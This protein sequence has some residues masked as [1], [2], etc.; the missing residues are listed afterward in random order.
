MNPI[1]Y[2]DF[3]PQETA[4]GGLF[5][6][7]DYSNFEDCVAAMNH[8][9]ERNPVH[10]IQCET[11]TLPNMHNISEDGSHDTELH[12]AGHTIWYQFLRLWY[13]ES[14]SPEA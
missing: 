4:R 9:L 1:K 8:W 6:G 11:V 13:S 5:G 14:D 10:V 12:A 3:L 7:V 2:K